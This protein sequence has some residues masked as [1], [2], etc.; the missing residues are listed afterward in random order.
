MGFPGIGFVGRRMMSKIIIRSGG[1]A[2]VAHDGFSRIGKRKRIRLRRR[3]RILR[4]GVHVV[5][6]GSSSEKS[7][8][9]GVNAGHV[10]DAMVFRKTVITA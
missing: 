2:G 9:V 8:N 10:V 7:L 6:Y 3:V 5:I 4:S 1:V